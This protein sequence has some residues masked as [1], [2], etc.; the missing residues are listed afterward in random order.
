[1]PPG[2][3]KKTFEEHV[4]RRIDVAPRE[5]STELGTAHVM[6]APHL[7]TFERR[8]SGVQ[9]MT[10]A[11]SVA[12]YGSKALDAL[13]LL[14][15]FPTLCAVAVEERFIDLFTGLPLEQLVRDLVD[16]SVEGDQAIARAAPFVPA[17]GLSRLRK[18]SAEARP[19][20][21]VAEREF[22]KATVEAKIEQLCLEIDGLAAEIAR[23]G[24]PVSED[25]RTSMLIAVRRRSDFEKRRQELN[26]G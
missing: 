1:V 6:P 15:A 26:R 19:E 5:A 7:S 9:A 14:A 20:S 10:V 8:A 24:S 23:G 22:R 13:G 17:Q 4:V 2:A 25:L 12:N 16:G 11:S 3:Q 21:G 18:L